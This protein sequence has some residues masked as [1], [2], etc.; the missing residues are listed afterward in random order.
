MNSRKA[1]RAQPQNN[2]NLPAN[3]LFCNRMVLLFRMGEVPKLEP[4]KVI[5]KKILNPNITR[6]KTLVTKRSISLADEHG[7]VSSLCRFSLNMY[8]RGLCIGLYK[9]CF[10]Q[11]RRNQE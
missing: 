5:S 4:V 1:I 10:S 3:G 8:R 7:T 11:L 2:R 9:Q 6:F